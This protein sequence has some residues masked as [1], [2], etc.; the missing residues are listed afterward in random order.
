L[1]T[2]LS[3]DDQNTSLA[4]IRGKAPNTYLG[5]LIKALGRLTR[6]EGVKRVLLECAQSSACDDLSR[7]CAWSALTRYATKDIYDAVKVS[8]VSLKG[9]GAGFW[10]SIQQTMDVQRKHQEQMAP[11]RSERTWRG[12]EAI[13]DKVLVAFSLADPV[14]LDDLQRAL[15]FAIVRDHAD[16]KETVMKTLVG[17]SKHVADHNQ[18]WCTHSDLSSHL[19]AII[20]NE[21]LSRV[22]L[23]DEQTCKDIEANL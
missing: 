4:V 19:R 14:A 5:T 16:V 18:P 2:Q 12:M 1:V 23:L 11:I 15:Q 7:K 13:K 20:S 10:S 8:Q 9:L 17:I 6:R 21:R 3:L 22:R